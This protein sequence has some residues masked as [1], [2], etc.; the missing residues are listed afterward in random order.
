[1]PFKSEKQRQFMHATPDITGAGS[2]RPEDLAGQTL[3]EE[4]I[5]MAEAAKD[6]AAPRPPTRTKEGYPRGR[7]LRGQG[8][9]LACHD[10][11]L[12]D[13]RTETVPKTRAIAAAPDETEELGPG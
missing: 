5:V 8:R 10:D 11:R 7:L 2:A 6:K 12:G 13:G 9:P 4:R 1:M 3:E